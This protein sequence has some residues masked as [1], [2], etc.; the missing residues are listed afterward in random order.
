MGQPQVN[1]ETEKPKKMIRRD[2]FA[3][4]VL[5][6]AMLWSRLFI[7]FEVHGREHLDHD[8]AYVI[9]A[10]HVSYFDG[11]WIMTAIGVRRILRFHAVAGSDLW[12]KYGRLGRLMMRVGAAIPLDRE[13][14][15]VSGVLSA[16]RCLDDRQIILIHPEGTRSQDGKLSEIH[17]SAA[18]LSRR[19]EVPLLPCYLDGAYEIFGRHRRKPSCFRS[20]F[21]RRRLVI[22]FAEPLDPAQYISSRQMT[23]DLSKVLLSM[24]ASRLTTEN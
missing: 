10:N 7:R 18:L 21:R 12:T 5:L 6:L 24:E 22:R 19:A 17:G 1:N 2:F 16:K 9:A 11:L 4:I 15:A 13:G 8:G 20:L 23:R 3:W 14:S